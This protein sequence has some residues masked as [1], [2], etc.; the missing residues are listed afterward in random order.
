LGIVKLF[1]ALLSSSPLLCGVLLEELASKSPSIWTYGECLVEFLTL[2]RILGVAGGSIGRT[3]ADSSGQTGDICST[4]DAM[5]GIEF[6][7]D[8]RRDVVID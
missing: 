1:G 5:V 8:G 6:E 4:A 7:D 3:A 2:W